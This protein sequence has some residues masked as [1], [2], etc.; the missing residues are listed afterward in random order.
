MN[1]SDIRKI[2][3]I[4]LAL[5][6]LLLGGGYAF[7]AFEGIGWHGV[8]ALVVGVTLSL[9]LGV[10]LMALMYASNRS[11]DEEAHLAAKNTFRDDS[12]PG[13]VPKSDRTRK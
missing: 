13:P 10:G 4:V 6:V 11:H 8:G 2:I 7:G 12:E 3:I 1:R 5:T 9:A